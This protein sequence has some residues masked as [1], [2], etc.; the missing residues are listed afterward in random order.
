LGGEA[1]DGGKDQRKRL[2][3]SY[4]KAI[5]NTYT[6][7]EEVIAFMAKHLGRPE[8]EVRRMRIWDFVLKFEKVKR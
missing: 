3:R 1:E 7:A 5:E 6:S 4:R 2:T 8:S